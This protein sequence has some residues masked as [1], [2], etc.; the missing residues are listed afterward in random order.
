MRK[1]RPKLLHELLHE[2]EV[3]ERGFSLSACPATFFYPV[4]NHDFWAAMAYVFNVQHLNPNSRFYRLCGTAV[5][6]TYV[7]GFAVNAPFRVGLYDNHAW[8][9]YFSQ[10][11]QESTSISPRI[12]TDDPN[13]IGQYLSPRWQKHVAAYLEQRHNERIL[14]LILDYSRSSVRPT[15]RFDNSTVKK[16][17]QN[18]I[19]WSKK[20]YALPH[21]E[22][23]LKRAFRILN[24]LPRD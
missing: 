13:V 19:A 21:N 20:T 2:Q 16:V 15:M 12:E 4:E 11:K 10:E 23:Y 1:Y 9:R 5:H 24:Q 22:R 3:F 7:S 8:Y 18:Y 14:E 6:Y 17:V